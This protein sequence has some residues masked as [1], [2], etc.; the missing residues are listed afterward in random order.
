M[1]PTLHH[2]EQ[3]QLLR[4]LHDLRTPGL[5]RAGRDRVPLLSRDLSEPGLSGTTPTAPPADR[6][7]SLRNALPLHSVQ[8]ENACGPKDPAHLRRVQV[9]LLH[10]FRP[11]WPPVLPAS[12]A[13]RFARSSQVRVLRLRDMSVPAARMRGRL[14]LP[15]PDGLSRLHGRPLLSPLP[16]LSKLSLRRLRLTTT[17]AQ[18]GCGPHR[19]SRLS[20]PGP[21]TL[22]GL[23][24]SVSRM[25]PSLSPLSPAPPSR[26]PRGPGLLCLPVFQ[27]LRGIH[28]HR[29]QCQGIRRLPG[30]GLPGLPVRASQD[31]AVQRHQV[32][33]HGGGEG[34]EPP[35]SRLS[36]LLSHEVGR[37]AQG[38]RPDRVLQGTL[39]PPGQRT[40]LLELRGPPPGSLLL[41]RRPHD[42]LGPRRL[43]RLARLC[44]H[45]GIRLLEGVGGLLRQRRRHPEKSL[46]GIPASDAPDHQ[47][48]TPSPV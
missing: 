34:P 31:R 32:D 25:H 24:I 47:H 20:R 35:I 11:A 8:Q 1:L 38:V 14:P 18:S 40:S 44:L 7:Q 48:W 46:S 29:P 39:S 23:R 6:T 10:L 41:R 33:V 17:R 5:S 42:S 16:D 28:L 9:S 22:R 21:R 45:P 2:Q 26:L 13:S 36:Q 4:M 12:P 15:T 43:P 37:P 3:T 27:A 19:L 30:P